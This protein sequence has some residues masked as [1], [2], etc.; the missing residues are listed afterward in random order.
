[1]TLPNFF[2]IGA[3][4]CGT[5]ALY[6][7]LNQHPQ[8]YMSHFKEP[9]F[10]AL[11]GKKLDF[12]GPADRR[13]INRG[14]FT[15]IE[16]YR[17]LFQDASSEKIIGEASTLYL[18]SQKAPERISHHVPGAKLVA[19]LRNPVE[20]AYSAFLHLVR[21]GNEPL[22]DFAQALREEEARIADNWGPVYH[23]KQRGFYYPQLKH[24]FDRFDRDQIRVYLYEDLKS[25]P[26]GMAR[27]IFRF[28]DVDD[29][30][31]PDVSV[32]HN[33][34]GIPTSATLQAL[35]LLVGKPN[36]VKTALRPLFPT[37]VRRGMRSMRLRAVRSIQSRNLAKAPRMSPEVR[38]ELSEAYR[39]DILMLQDLLQRD[40]SGWLK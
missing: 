20:R 28:L 29:A 13:G 22:S 23:Y 33:V 19:V 1:M 6:H 30:F 12:R 5:T 27:D 40:L 10:F 25:D 26:S 15:D 2:I 4:K 36:P 14:G 39:E 7:F 11:E 16:A 35:Y 37:R 31:A 34:S 9:R 24:Y 17:A 38:A 21:D 8:I 3:A 32:K 18:Y